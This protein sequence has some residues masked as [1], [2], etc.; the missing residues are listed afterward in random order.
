MH[1]SFSLQENL[2]N[3]QGIRTLSRDLHCYLQLFAA[4]EIV[5]AT[6][7]GYIKVWG[8]PQFYQYAD[9]G[10]PS[11]LRGFRNNRFRGES[12]FFQNID[13]RMHLFEWNNNISPMH[14]GIL[15]GYHYGWVWLTG[16]G[17]DVWHNSMTVGV[18]ME[19]LGSAILQPYHSIN[20]EQNQFSLK[21]GF[22]F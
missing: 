2:S 8:Q 1:N 3:S 18:F 5:L 10:N 19:I 12:A 11:N 13:L 7:I 20:D 4:P 22:N 16:E 6:N 15:G 14:I 9:L 17:L 21:L